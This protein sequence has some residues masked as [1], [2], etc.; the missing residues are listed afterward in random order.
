MAFGHGKNSTVY[1][2]GLKA[3]DYLSK[4]AT[5]LSC[6]VHDSTPFGKNS[7]T[8]IAGIK[9]GGVN[10]AGLYDGDQVL[11]YDT[12]R[13]ALGSSSDALWMAFWQGDVLSSPGMAYRSVNTDYTI[14]SPVSGLVSITAG[15]QADNDVDIVKSLHAL[16]AETSTG[17]GPT[18][19]ESA[20]SSAGCAAHLHVT[21]ITGTNIIVKV[22]HGAASD[23]SDA[24]DLLTFT[25]VTAALSAE[26]QSASGTVKRY[27]RYNLSGTFTSATFVLGWSRK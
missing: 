24:S 15:G 12:F 5:K 19:D 7:K 17:N 2:N 21:A 20:A 18:L 27:I 9:D 3:T 25:S 4:I 13:R 14:S 6:S 10:G 26:R 22:Q 16:G 11:V 23:M 1:L 8:F